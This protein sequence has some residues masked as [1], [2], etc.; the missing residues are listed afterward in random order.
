M[1]ERAVVFEKQTESM[2]TIKQLYQIA[3]KCTLQIPN[4][5]QQCDDRTPLKLYSCLV[6]HDPTRQALYNKRHPKET[7][8]NLVMIISLAHI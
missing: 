6:H 5:H 1:T 8:V 7:T 4:K 3:K 2:R